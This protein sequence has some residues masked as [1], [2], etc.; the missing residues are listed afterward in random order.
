[1]KYFVKFYII[2]DRRRLVL[3]VLIFFILS[4]YSV[5]HLK[6]LLLVSK[7]E[8]FSILTLNVW[9][10][11]FGLSV[12]KEKRIYA[13][14][15]AIVSTNCDVVCLQELWTKKDVNTM[16][17]IVRYTHPYH[18][19]FHSG[20]IGSGLCIF[21][22]WKIEETFYYTFPINGFFHMVHHGDWFG[23]KG[24][25]F[26]RININGL[27]IHIY[28]THLHA[29]YSEEGGMDHYY[30]HRLVQAFDTAL[31]IKHTSASA[32]VSILGADLNSTPEDSCTKLI[33]GLADLED[34]WEIADR[35]EAFPETNDCVRNTFR[36]KTLKSNFPGRRIDYIL[37]KT[38]NNI[39]VNVPKCIF[40]FEDRIPGTEIS[41]SDHEAVC[42]TFYCVDDQKNTKDGKRTAVMKEMKRSLLENLEISLEMCRDEIGSHKKD[43]KRFLSFIIAFCIGL[44]FVP[45]YISDYN[46]SKFLIAFGAGFICFETVLL[47]TRWLDMAWL[48]NAK[49]R[50]K[51]YVQSGE[52]NYLEC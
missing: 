28:N 15:Q 5:G 12:N 40:P 8:K 39:M 48:K 24:I 30:A 43:I 27:R 1:M 44:F 23:G 46:I 38:K 32:D 51:I 31:F 6:I 37:F 3:G 33:R 35:R 18:H 16:K 2:S 13:I 49:K 29:D 36:C 26:V 11:P 45:F 42:A 9:G 25:G 14:A 19:Y 10:L 7:M 52:L 41:Y 20:I 4:L 17:E 22:K 21:S 47:C 50:F 34:A